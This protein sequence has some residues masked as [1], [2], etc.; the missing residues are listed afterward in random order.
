MASTLT[1]LSKFSLQPHSTLVGSLTT[2]SVCALGTQPIRE[3]SMKAKLGSKIC[4]TDETPDKA[5]GL[6][7][8]MLRKAHAA[9]SW[10]AL[11]CLHSELHSYAAYRIK[12][13]WR[14]RLIHT[15]QQIGQGS[16]T[17][18]LQSLMYSFFYWEMFQQISGTDFPLGFPIADM[19]VCKAIPETIQYC[20]QPFEE[21]NITE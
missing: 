6:A 20:K 9:L 11:T 19:H 17:F 16:K 7:P 18:I 12:R 21:E 3:S 13:D 2:S 4:A 14:T 1:G 8:K 5:R 15:Y 10:I